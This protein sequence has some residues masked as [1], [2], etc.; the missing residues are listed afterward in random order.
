VLKQAQ[1]REDAK[2]AEQAEPVGRGKDT[3]H[4]DVSG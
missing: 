2:D 3:V 1:A 4:D